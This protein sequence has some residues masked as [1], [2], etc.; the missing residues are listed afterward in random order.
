[1]C[2][3]TR[4]GGLWQTMAISRCLG[5]TAL[6]C[7]RADHLVPRP[8]T[9]KP[10]QA[11]HRGQTTLIMTMCTRARPTKVLTCSTWWGLLCQG[12]W[13]KGTTTVGPTS[14]LG[15]L[16][17][18]PGGIRQTIHGRAPRMQERTPPHASAPILPLRS[19]AAGV[20]KYHTSE[21]AQLS[22]VLTAPQVFR[23][24]P[25]VADTRP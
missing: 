15:M 4:Q 13:L 23:H 7:L 12:A 19:E 17:Q 18:A 21:P 16:P 1:M 5:D 6:P 3:A 11:K 2:I 22:L 24:A 8:A 25:Q 20:A 14:R 9:T 10:P